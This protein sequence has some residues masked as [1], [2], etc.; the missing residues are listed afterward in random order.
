[1]DCLPPSVGGGDMSWVDD[2]VNVIPAS[3]KKWARKYPNARAAYG[4]CKNGEHLALWVGTF[5]DVRFQPLNPMVVRLGIALTRLPRVKDVPGYAAQLVYAYA[6][7]LWC[8]DG[9]PTLIPVCVPV[10]AE[11]MARA[12]RR[13]S[14][15]TPAQD[16]AWTARGA[17]PKVAAGVVRAHFP[18]F[19]PVRSSPSTY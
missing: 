1:M 15:F 19:T 6:L 17:D 12:T 16:L 4:A 13:P 9:L 14:A 7:E 5:H 18:D 2:P 3:L 11:E 10:T 8:N